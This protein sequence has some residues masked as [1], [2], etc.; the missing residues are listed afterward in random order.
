MSVHDV[1]RARW[2]AVLEHVS[3][4]HCGW[5]ASLVRVQRGSMLTCHTGWHPLARVTAEKG[6][7]GAT[8]IRITFEDG[9]TVDVSA[10]RALGIDTCADGARRALE[11]ETVRDEFVRLAFRDATNP[12]ATDG[13]ALSDS[14]PPVR[15]SPQIRVR[16]ERKTPRAQDADR[17]SASASA[18]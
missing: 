9:P 14:S 3:R 1:Q 7:T 13:T 12:E 17:T 2:A 11:I 8:T 5:L 16:A 15:N 4:T 6:P 10:L 18:N